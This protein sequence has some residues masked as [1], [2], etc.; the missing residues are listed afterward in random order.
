M[1]CVAWEMT[2]PDGDTVVST[3]TNVITF[4]ADGRIRSDWQFVNP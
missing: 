3:G 1:L 2:A 4:A